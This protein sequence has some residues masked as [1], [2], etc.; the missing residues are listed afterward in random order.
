MEATTNH[1]LIFLLS[2]TYKVSDAE[3]HHSAPPLCPRRNVHALIIRSIMQSL[4]R[5][6]VEYTPDIHAIELSLKYGCSHDAIS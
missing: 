4:A 2:V 1:L 3:V 5:L 6:V